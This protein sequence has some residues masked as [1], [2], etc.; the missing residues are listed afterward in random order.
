MSQQYPGGYVTKTVPTVSTAAAP[1]MWTL[2]QAAQ[3]QAAGTW[4]IPAGQQ[5]FTTPGTYSWTAPVDVKSVCV[6]CVGGGGSGYRGRPSYGGGGGGG[7]GLGYINNYAVT[8]G[9]TYTIVVGTGGSLPSSRSS[10]AGSDSYFVSTSVVKG[11]GGVGGQDNGQPDSAGGTYVGDG[12]GN[13][14]VGGRAQGFN[15]GS[16]GG[17]GGG[18]YSGTGGRGTTDDRTP[19]ASAGSGGGGGGGGIYSGGGG[20]G[21]LGQGSNGTAGTD[22][23]GGGGGSGGT[24][25]GAGASANPGGSY[26][27]GGGGN[28]GVAEGSLVGGGGAIRIIWGGGRAF[29]ST[30]TGDV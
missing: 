17:G 8:P 12:G 9:N 21:I 25:G 2:D 16:G 7:G 6:V 14:G 1:G 26:G 18:G 4:P 27:G 19:P 23:V 13:G 22:G 3:Y 10:N 30:N 15:A 28:D 29:P 20:T 11:S 24:N 5:A